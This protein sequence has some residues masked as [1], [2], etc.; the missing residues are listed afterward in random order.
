MPAL[1]GVANEAFVSHAPSAVAAQFR[2]VRRPSCRLRDGNVWKSRTSDSCYGELLFVP[3]REPSDVLRKVVVWTSK[4]VLALL[5]AFTLFPQQRD[6][7][8]E[9]FSKKSW[10]EQAANTFCILV[11]LGRRF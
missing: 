5:M 8:N 7:T 9:F 3:Q 4:R 1:R 2:F 6:R 10:F 11:F